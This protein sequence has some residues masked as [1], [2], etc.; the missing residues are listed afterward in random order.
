MFHFG[1]CFI[2]RIIWDFVVSHLLL[3]PIREPLHSVVAS[4]PLS[5]HPS[6]LG[7]RWRKRRLRGGN[8]REDKT[9]LGCCMGGR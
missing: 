8:D 3:S 7:A 6:S 9:D 5:H 2:N 4:W 1:K